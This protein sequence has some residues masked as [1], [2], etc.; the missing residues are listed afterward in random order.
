MVEWVC[1]DTTG[2]GGRVSPRGGG[3]SPSVTDPVR[4]RG[5]GCDNRGDQG[6]RQG[7]R[8]RQTPFARGEEGFRQRGGG[9]NTTLDTSIKMCVNQTQ[10]RGNMTSSDMDSAQEAT[11][12]SFV[13]PKGT[14]VQR[15]INRVELKWR[16][17]IDTRQRMCSNGNVTENTP[18]ERNRAMTTAT[19][20]AIVVILEVPIWAL[21]MRQMETAK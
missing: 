6:A 14:R 10:L 20:L 15:R 4:Q 2:C 9:C 19:I 13:Q 11:A 21:W 12:G 3:V 18:I 1:Q 16:S 7:T 8:V 5:P 17:P